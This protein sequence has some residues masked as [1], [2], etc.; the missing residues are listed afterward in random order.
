MVDDCYWLDEDCW[1]QIGKAQ[2]SNQNV[3]GWIQQWFF[4]PDAYQDC[5]VEY[6]SNQS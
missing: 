6:N 3:K 1:Y 2:V 4:L 5:Q